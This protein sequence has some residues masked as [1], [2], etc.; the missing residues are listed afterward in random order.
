MQLSK[1]TIVKASLELLDVFGLAD[2]T[3]RRLSNHLEVAPAAIYWHFKN[4][5]VLIEATA[6][7]MLE[8]F[9]T[10]NH[11]DF[12]CACRH[13]R[14]SL[15]LYR[16]GA[17]LLSAAL[18]STSLRE[19]IIR[20]LGADLAPALRHD[21]ATTALHFIVGVTVYDQLEYQLHADVFGSVSDDTFDRGLDLLTTGIQHISG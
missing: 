12:A 4:K 18:L 15:L 21:A 19:D 9:L 1:D 13:L 10:A 3:M 2:M 16:D 7:G 20:V 11:T 8:K 17:E 14:R 6:R 5:Q